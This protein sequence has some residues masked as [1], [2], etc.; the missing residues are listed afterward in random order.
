[1]FLKV[2]SVFSGDDKS[3]IVAGFRH[4]V[5]LS[6]PV[7]DFR[8]RA[9]NRR[10]P[11]ARRTSLPHESR[12]Y[13]LTSQNPW[14]I[15]PI[16]FTIRLIKLRTNSCLLHYRKTMAKVSSYGVKPQFLSVFIVWKKKK[17]YHFASIFPLVL[18][19]TKKNRTIRRD[20]RNE[21]IASKAYYS[22]R[23]K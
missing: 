12:G 4:S 6:L 10:K 23:V 9:L 22:R 16:S 13:C 21:N 2:T 18:L 19:L 20:F 3:L 15:I 5:S 11:L 1:M 17:M 7:F 14:G 8:H